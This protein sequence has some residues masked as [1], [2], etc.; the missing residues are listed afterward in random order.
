MTPEEN[1]NKVCFPI[2]SR[3]Q[4]GTEDVVTLEDARAAVAAARTDGLGRDVLLLKLRSAIADKEWAI[5]C[6]NMETERGGWTCDWYAAM[7]AAH[8]EIESLLK[9]L[10][11]A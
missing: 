7:Q 6:A 9:V 8:Q 5:A 11:V 1:L 10:C 4:S 3:L 2:L